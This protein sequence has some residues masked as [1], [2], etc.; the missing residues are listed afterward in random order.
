RWAQRL[1]VCPLYLQARTICCARHTVTREGPLL[2]P[3]STSAAA[4]NVSQGGRRFSVDRRGP[5]STVVFLQVRPIFCV[6]WSIVRHLPRAPPRLCWSCYRL[7]KTRQSA[8]HE[9]R[10]ACC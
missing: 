4:A 9:E 2:S 3:S 7:C 6:V 5:P 10:Q 8:G 1:Q